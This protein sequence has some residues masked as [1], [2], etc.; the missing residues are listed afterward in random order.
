M[1][2]EPGN[3]PKDYDLSEIVFQN[4]VSRMMEKMQEDR[5]L[6]RIA[7]LSMGEAYD[8]ANDSGKM[9]ISIGSK[10]FDVE[11]QTPAS[12][13]EWEREVQREV[14]KQ[15]AK[16]IERDLLGDDFF[17]P[18]NHSKLMD[19]IDVMRNTPRGQRIAF[20]RC[21]KSKYNIDTSRF[22]IVIDE[23]LMDKAGM[24][25]PEDTNLVD[26]G[27]V[28]IDFDEYGVEYESDQKPHFIL[29]RRAYHESDER[30]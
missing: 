6:G 4:H 12:M 23:K 22:D 16:N 28:V 20:K 14:G 25:F 26:H 17:N 18:Q 7:K 10:E 13:L 29:I 3:S 21:L 11:M 8:M 15:L 27:I 5:D 19:D 24:E 2:N 1:P 30:I 9:R